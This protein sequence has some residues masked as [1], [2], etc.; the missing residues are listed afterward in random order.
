MRTGG[1]STENTGESGYLC[2]L[3]RGKSGLSESEKD[4]NL[5]FNSRHGTTSVDQLSEMEEEKLKAIL[6][7]PLEQM[8]CGGEDVETV[9]ERLRQADTQPDVCGKVFKAGET[10]YNCKDCGQDATC[11]LCVDCF[12]Q[13]EHKNHRYRMSTSEGGGYCDCGDPEAFKL[14]PRCQKHELG[15]GSKQSPSEVLARFPEGES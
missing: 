15:E 10:C 12:T 5:I 14:F 2:S 3:L 1:T 9:W 7:K 6:L 8:I 11:V 4:V 13:S